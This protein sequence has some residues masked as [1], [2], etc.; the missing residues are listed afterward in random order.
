MQ[1]QKPVFPLCVKDFEDIMIVAVST[2]ILEVLD[3]MIVFSAILEGNGIEWP[4]NEA[5]IKIA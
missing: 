3:A 1:L 4:E 2:K 5:I